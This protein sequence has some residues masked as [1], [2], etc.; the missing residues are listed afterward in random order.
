MKFEMKKRILALALAGTT[1][2]SVFGAAMSAGAADSTHTAVYND[3]YVSYESVAKTIKARAEKAERSAPDVIVIDREGNKTDHAEWVWNNDLTGEGTIDFMVYDYTTASHKS[4]QPTVFAYDFVYNNNVYTSDIAG[5]WGDPVYDVNT[6][7]LVK[8][9]WAD[10]YNIE[11]LLHDIYA[12]NCDEAIYYANTSEMVYLMQRYVAREIVAISG[13]S[14]IWQGAQVIVSKNA[15]K[16]GWQKV[17]GKWYYMSKE[18]NSLGQML[19]NTTVEGY[20]LGADGA[21]I[22]K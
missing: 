12:L 2:F 4:Y 18:S 5:A 19:S 10:L 1:A 7:K 15:M 8:Y 9:E 22:E 13:D 17:D 14:F 6:G 11:Q 16:T 21:M 3:A 20:A